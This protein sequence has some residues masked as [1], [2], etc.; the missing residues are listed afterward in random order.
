MSILLFYIVKKTTEFLLVSES[1]WLGDML[2]GVF[3]RN[4]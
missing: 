3:V 2:G 1:V 4:I